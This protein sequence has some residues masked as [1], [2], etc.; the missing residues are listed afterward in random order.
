M[1]TSDCTIESLQP[2]FCMTQKEFI[3]DYWTSANVHD[4][5][6]SQSNYNESIYSKNDQSLT[7]L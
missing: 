5:Q 1:D 2:D 7:L 6:K 3:L 4:M